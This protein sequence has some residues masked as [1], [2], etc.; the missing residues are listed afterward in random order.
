MFIA[1]FLICLYLF[2]LFDS[3]NVVLCAQINHHDQVNNNNMVVIDDFLNDSTSKAY[4]QSGFIRDNIHSVELMMLYR[5]R[6][7]FARNVREA[8][9]LGYSIQGFYHVS[10]WQSRWKEVVLE[11]MQ[12]LDGFR[13]IPTNI[14]RKDSDH[15][16][17]IPPKPHSTSL[18][19]H[20]DG[21]Y[22]IYIYIVIYYIVIY[23]YHTYILCI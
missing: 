8:K 11:Q 4:Y 15:Y 23:I 1:T 7:L 9:R 16:K 17:L 19:K 2:V 20:S 6:E 14:N 18:L 12:Y 13:Y 22:I 21:I 5:E 10:T 3:N